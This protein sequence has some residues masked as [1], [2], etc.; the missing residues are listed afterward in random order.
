MSADRFGSVSA[1]AYRKPDTVTSSDPSG[2]TE[3]APTDPGAN[4]EIN[5]HEL[6]TVYDPHSAANVNLTQKDEF[7]EH[8]AP[9]H[10]A[11]KWVHGHDPYK[12]LGMPGQTY[13]D[14]S[15]SV[16]TSDTEAPV[17]DGGPA[18]LS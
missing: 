4:T 13:L 7:S 12:H 1:G 5:K 18:T 6:T 16:E 15:T 17:S 2:F 14:N 10:A 11:N 3:T 8:D 9:P